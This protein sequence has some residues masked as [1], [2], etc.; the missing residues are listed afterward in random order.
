MRSPRRVA[1]LLIC[2]GL[3]AQQQPVLRTNV[4]VVEVSVVATDAKGRRPED[5]RATDFRVWDNGK[6]QAV[7]SLELLKLPVVR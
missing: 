2:T 5:L 1:S 6:E 7:A 4:H 3:F